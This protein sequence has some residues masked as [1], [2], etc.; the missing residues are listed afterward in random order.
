MDSSP[1]QSIAAM[2]KMFDNVA[3]RYD[4]ANLAMSLGRDRFWRQSLARR[5][6]I[7]TPPGRL[8]D[9]AAGTGDQ[10]VAAKKA[11]PHLEAVGLDLSPAM[12]DL[13]EAKFNALEAPRPR[14]IIGDALALPFEEGEFDSVSMSFGLRNVASRAKLF[15]EALRVLKPG[16]R[17]LILEMYFDQAAPWAAFMRWYLQ[18][19]VPF[20]GGR[21]LSSE[22]EAYKYLVSSVMAFP[23]PEI[24]AQEMAA[25]GFAAPRVKTYTLN[26]VMLVWGDKPC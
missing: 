19:I 8:L 20:L 2:R 13:A 17:I 18:K 26:S 3:A 25:A 21:L 15:A 7:L 12:M 4:L 24:A 5:L 6:K 23:R 14:M 9:L 11:W 22:R 1:R 10:I 16:G